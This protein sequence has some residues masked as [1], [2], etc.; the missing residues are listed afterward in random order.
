M[1]NEKAAP[2]LESFMIE[3]YHDRISE[4]AEMNESLDKKDFETIRQYAHKWKGFCV[5]YGFHGL[6]ALSIELEESCLG[7]NIENISGLLAKVSHYMSE[8][9]KVLNIVED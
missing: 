1:T 9:K 5:P 6:E 8:K 7:Q 2:G 3:F 4:L